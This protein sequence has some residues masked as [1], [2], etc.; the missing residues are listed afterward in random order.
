MGWNAFSFGMDVLCYTKAYNDLAALRGVYSEILQRM[1]AMPTLPWEWSGLD[2]Q[3]MADK[4]C[5]ELGQSGLFP[6]YWAEG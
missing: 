3:P 1:S 5:R 4:E 2:F 6:G